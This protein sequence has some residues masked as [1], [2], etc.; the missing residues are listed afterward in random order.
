MQLIPEQPQPLNST[1][2]TGGYPVVATA[3]LILVMVWGGFASQVLTTPGLSYDEA[4]FGGMAKDFVT[5]HP[6]GLHMPGSH[7]IELFGR[8]FPLFVQDY[9]GALKPWLLMPSLSLFGASVPV[10]RLTSLALSL[11]GLLVLMLWTGRWLGL[12]TALL[13]GALLAMD[14]TF[15]FLSLLDCGAAVTSFV[16]R[17]GGFYL[18][19]LWW[20]Q[21]RS[22]YAFLAGVF[23][24]LGLFNKVDSVVVLGGVGCAALCWYA[25]PFWARLC[26][27]PL[28]FL[29]AGSG[30]LLAA[31]PTILRLPDILAGPTPHATPGAGGEW[32][33]KTGT[34]MAMY[35][36]SY[37]YRL[38]A[39]GGMFLKMFQ[40]GTPRIWE[41][42]GLA[43]VSAG[44][45]C[46]V[47]LW[48]GWWHE[49]L[50]RTICFLLLS[51]ILVT[52]GVLLL[53]G[54]VRMYH[55]ILVYPFPH[56]IVAATLTLV[57]RRL[58][59]ANRPPTF[60]RLL[61]PTVVAFLLLGQVLAIVKTENL[62]RR[63]GGQGLWSNALDTFAGEIKNRSDLTIVSLDWGFHESL[64]F[65]TQGPKLVEP[66]WFWQQG[67]LPGTA[68]TTN[69]AYLIHPPKYRM[70]TWEQD[71]SD[72]AF[73]AA[74]NLEC[75][76]YTD[77]T[78]SVA[79]YV[80][81]TQS[82]SR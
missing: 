62:M 32:A 27:R 25:R 65:L 37:N 42:F 7:V 63:T 44:L 70:F 59:G 82:P 31:A 43:V 66:F 21:G 79:F 41:P 10:F 12:G 24:G 38:M 23:F 58:A 54:A 52:S 14:P 47:G 53:P 15:F 72:P 40:Q 69:C 6:H 33:E 76:P 30:F 29:L 81:R 61:L 75:R 18:T 9:L 49:S 3:W 77:R 13:A 34:L 4:I 11:V 74:H 22:S 56:L 19:W 50:R 1:T 60:P 26:E 48:R 55:S 78:G 36:G 39:V 67:L 51:G 20:K 46:V 16:C 28:T 17:T 68:G 5:G 45:L 8:P 80:I 64:L 57:W 2:L 71:Y 35:D 73:L